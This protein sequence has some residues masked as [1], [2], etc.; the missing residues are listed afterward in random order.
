MAET[1]HSD[2]SADSSVH[3]CARDRAR[4]ARELAAAGQLVRVSHLAAV[5]DVDVS[6]VYDHALE[7]GALRLGSGP[8]AP[9]R[10]DLD[11]ALRRLS[12]CSASRRSPE[13]AAAQQAAPRRRSRAR[14]GTNVDLLPIR[15]RR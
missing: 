10:F 9:L 15:G 5:L 7:L 2:R 13:P 4:E 6:Y 8:K 3:V 1:G 12:S 14:L 11:E